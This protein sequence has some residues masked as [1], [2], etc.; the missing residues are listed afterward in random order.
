MKPIDIEYRPDST[1]YPF[2]ANTYG[3]QIP[4]TVSE[5]EY[6]LFQITNVLKQ[7]STDHQGESK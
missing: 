5:L 1:K 3:D 4:L 2:A 6:L 7:H